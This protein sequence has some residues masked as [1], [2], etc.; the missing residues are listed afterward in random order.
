VASAGFIG[1]IWPAPRFAAE[2]ALRA[3]ST[4]EP[5]INDTLRTSLATVVGWSSN[6]A[7]ASNRRAAR[8]A[9]SS[10]Q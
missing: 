9:E 8:E 10:R 4:P 6:S 5:S 1:P 3:A 7:Q 2:E